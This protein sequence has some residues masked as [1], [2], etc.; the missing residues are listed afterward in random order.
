MCRATAMADLALNTEGSVGTVTVSLTAAET[1]ALLH[2]AAAAYG[3]QI[4]DLL[5]SALAKAVQPWIGRDDMLVDVEDHRRDDVFNDVD[6]S[7][8]IG[9]FTTL[10]PV[11]LEAG[12]GTPGALIKRTK[13]T[14]RRLH[15]R[16]LSFGAL[17]YLSPE[18]EVRTALEEVPR[19]QLAVQL[20]WTA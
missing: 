6:L 14:L 18:A 2:R 7:R 8:T 5:L 9:W 1:D 17:R 4:N 15:H 12:D 19:P 16:G 3:T 13:E 20:S 11:H 10:Y